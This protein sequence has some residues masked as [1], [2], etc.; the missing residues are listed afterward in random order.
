MKVAISL[1][2]AKD[3]KTPLKPLYASLRSVQTPHLFFIPQGR[4]TSPFK[5]RSPASGGR[6]SIIPTKEKNNLLSID[7]VRYYKG[8]QLKER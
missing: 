5:D 7:M 1:I 4:D 2:R 6:T 3:L 8:Y